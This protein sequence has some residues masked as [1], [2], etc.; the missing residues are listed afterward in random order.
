MYI[1]FKKTG[2]CKVYETLSKSSTSEMSITIIRPGFFLNVGLCC[3]VVLL[4]AVVWRRS[5]A[6]QCAVKVFCCSTSLQS[7]LLCGHWITADTY[8]CLVCLFVCMSVY[9]VVCMCMPL[10]P[11]LP[12]L[13]SVLVSVSVLMP[14]A[15]S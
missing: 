15:R 10:S 4:R 13:A 11:S 9:F 8:T 6:L 5:V 12:V 1:S 2:V 3:I 7:F 14:V